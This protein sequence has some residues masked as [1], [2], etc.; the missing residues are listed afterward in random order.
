MRILGL[1]PGLRHTGWGLIEQIGTHFASAL[2]TKS[3]SIDVKYLNVDISSLN[4]IAISF[5][6]FMDDNKTCSGRCIIL[7]A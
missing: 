6:N 3:V 2:T 1:D 5:N 4:T 7:W